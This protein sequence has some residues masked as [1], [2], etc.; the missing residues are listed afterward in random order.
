MN[1]MHPKGN[2]QAFQEVHNFSYIVLFYFPLS[3][4]QCRMIGDYEDLFTP[5]DDLNNLSQDDGDEEAMLNLIESLDED[6]EENFISYL[7]CQFEYNIFLSY[8]VAPKY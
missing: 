5:C 4:A 6:Y 8:C 7:T 1:K 3:V 2:E